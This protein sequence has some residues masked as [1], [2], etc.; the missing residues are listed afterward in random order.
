LTKCN[1]DNKILVVYGWTRSI[2]FANYSVL[3]W[4]HAMKIINLLIKIC[5]VTILHVALRHLILINENVKHR[6]N[7]ARCLLPQKLRIWVLVFNATFNNWNI[8]ESGLSTKTQTLTVA[9]K[10]II[11]RY[12]YDVCMVSFMRGW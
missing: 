7:N 5:V 10:A 4:R 11:S 2:K 9:E 6:K 8:V 12:F 3:T 1:E